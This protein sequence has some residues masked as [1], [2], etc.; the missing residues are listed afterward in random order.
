MMPTAT[1]SPTPRPSSSM[2]MPMK[3]ESEPVSF[4]PQVQPP[5]SQQVQLQHSQPPSPNTTTNDC[6]ILN[7]DQVALLNNLAI[8]SFENGLFY[9]AVQIYCDTLTHFCAA[10]QKVEDEMNDEDE[11]IMS[12]EDQQQPE[13][14]DY[15]AS[16]LQIQETQELLQLQPQQQQ[17]QGLYDKTTPI[18]PSSSAPPASGGPPSPRPYSF[19][20]H[21][22][23]IPHKSAFLFAQLESV[24]MQDML[25]PQDSSCS[26][27]FSS[28]RLQQQHQRIRRHQLISGILLFNFGLLHHLQAIK[29]SCLPSISSS[30]SDEKRYNFQCAQSSYC[31][32]EQAL[33]RYSPH[34]DACYDDSGLVERRLLLAI[35][36]NKACISFQF[37][38]VADCESQ[39]VALRNLLTTCC[40]VQVE[41]NHHELTAAAD[42]MAS[43]QDSDTNSS[44]AVGMISEDD[45]RC[46]HFF[47]NAI[48][49]AKLA[50][51]SPA[52]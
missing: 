17:H 37:W 28:L 39:L 42:A 16:G 2:I 5:P 36:N 3:T 30:S 1:M 46:R 23:L 11:D 13:L 19:L 4:S 27:L 14:T 7:I 33:L 45:D 41:S 43:P 29:I 26:S 20:D 50:M 31:M 34:F 48:S 18:M 47:W 35:Y 44:S 21:N 38:D 51:T 15:L 52:A 9:H 25:A 40:E 10:A 6:S 49:M 22:T 24:V 12:H 32:A 8:R